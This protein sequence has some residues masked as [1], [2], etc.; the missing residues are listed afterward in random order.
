MTRVVAIAVSVVVL[1]L[2]SSVVAQDRYPGRPTPAADPYAP[3][4]G[5]DAAPASKSPAPSS[6]RPTNPVSRDPRDFEAPARGWRDDVPLRG[7]VADD[8]APPRTANRGT[9]RGAT[10]SPVNQPT[11]NPV[12]GPSGAAGSFAPDRD[13]APIDADQGTGQPG[14]KEL[15]GPQAPTV[16][17]EKV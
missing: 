6:A 1:A 3:R 16:V 8:V 15:E 13:V 14:G 9:N 10:V 11:S 17:V 5:W 12:A 7:P 4:A 2:L